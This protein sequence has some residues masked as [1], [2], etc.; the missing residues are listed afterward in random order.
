MLDG[1]HKQKMAYALWQL[2]NQCNDRQQRIKI[3]GNSYAIARK[4][5]AEAH[6]KRML[7]N[8]PLKNPENLKKL[9]E[10]I[11]RRGP[12]SVKGRKMTEESKQ[13]LRDKEWTQKALDSRLQNCLKAAE[14]RKGSKWS[15]GR[16]ELRFQ[17]YLEKNKHLFPQVLELYDAG[18]NNRQISLKLGISWDRV[19]YIIVNRERINTI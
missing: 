2:S 8:H 15:S 7:T 19:K 16:H 5:F 1:E 4:W 9:R 3:T 17:Q 10:G 12:T 13:K 11:K 14:A 18:M 6:S